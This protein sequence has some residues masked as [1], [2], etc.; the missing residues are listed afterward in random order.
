MPFVPDLDFPE[1]T[2]PEATEQDMLDQGIL[3]REDLDIQ[4][5]GSHLPNLGPNIHDPRVL[6]GLVD[7]YKQFNAAA[8]ASSS[9][10]TNHSAFSPPP[11]DE[12]DRRIRKEFFRMLEGNSGDLQTNEDNPGVDTELGEVPDGDFDEEMPDEEL[13]EDLDGLHEDPQV[14]IVIDED[15]PD[16]FAPTSDDISVISPIDFSSQPPHLQVIYALVTWL[17]LQFHL[18]RI[19]CQT[20]LAV[21]ACLLFFLNPNFET[22]FVTLSSANRALSIDAP[23]HILAVCPTCK[24]VYPETGEASCTRCLSPLFEDKVTK[25]GKAR[26]TQIPL[27]R[28]PYLSITEQLSPILAIPGVEQ[29]MDQWRTI[30]R[31]PGYYQDIFD[32]QICKTLKAHDGSPFFSNGPDERNGPNDE[33]RLGLL[34]GADW[35][36]SF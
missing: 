30:E 17:H 28:Y 27:L 4:T 15:D 22:P 8:H 9:R 19:A 3:T 16:P 33:L 12:T 21:L 24:D 20:V 26:K 32:G 14:T 35:Y 1:W 18:P 31:R 5:F 7:Y 10:L 13:D 25:R 36:V 34:L 6:L 23:I 29:L 2:S 11:L